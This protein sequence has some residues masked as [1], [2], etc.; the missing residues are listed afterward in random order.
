MYETSRG[1]STRDLEYRSVI[2]YLRQKQPV[3][4]ATNRWVLSTRRNEQCDATVEGGDVL[5]RVSEESTVL[6]GEV[7]DDV[8]E[9]GFSGRLPGS[10]GDGPD[11][12]Y[13]R[14]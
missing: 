11:D 10:V 3:D 6:V 8:L 13:H 7:R 1:D 2:V 4:G 12:G 14:F 5:A 9:F